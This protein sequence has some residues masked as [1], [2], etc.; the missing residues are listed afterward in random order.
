MFNCVLGDKCSKT[1]ELT[2]PTSKP[3]A[4]WVKKDGSDDF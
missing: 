1:I 3:I 4:Y 2:N